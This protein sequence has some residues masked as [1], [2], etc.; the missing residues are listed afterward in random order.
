MTNISFPIMDANN[1]AV[2]ALTVPYIQRVPDAVGIDQVEA[3][4]A[5]TARSIS[6][7][8]GAR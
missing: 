4:L 8:L 3:V 7:A 6:S 5:E 2:A 1:R